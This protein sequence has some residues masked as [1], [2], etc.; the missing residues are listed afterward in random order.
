MPASTLEA[1]ALRLSAPPAPDALARLAGFAERLLDVPV[2]LITLAEGRAWCGPAAGARWQPRR[3]T[4]LHRS[5]CGVPARTGRTLLVE[6]A[7]AHPLVRENPALWMGEVA[8]A[9]APIRTA[10]GTV[11]GSI[12]A[13]DTR[14]RTWTGEDAEALEHLAAL[15]GV[16]LDR[17]QSHAG[18]AGFVGAIA[19]S[20]GRLS[21]RMLEKA[22]ETMQIGVTITDA[23]G[24]ILYSNPAEARMHGYAADELR[25]MHARVFAPP[26]HA[27]PI[28]RQE[29][30][31]VTS[32]MRETVNVRKD[33]TLFPVLLRSDVVK[34]SRGNVVGI[35]TCCEDIT[36]R[37]EMER[38]LLRNAFFDPVTG[39]PNRGLFSHRLELAVDRER[40]GEGDFAVLA[41]GIDR[42]ALIGES[43]GREAADELLA[44]VAARVRE[45]VKTETLVAHVARDE[46]AVL[47]D[48]VEGIA[49][50]SRVAACIQDSL[51]RPFPVAG[52]E[53]ATGASVG[54]ALSY[55][56]YERAED[57]LRDAAIALGRSRDARQGQYEVFDRE[58][59][60]R[61]MARLRMETELR[62]ALDRGE[63]R[64]H[65]QPIISLD[66]GRIAGF[67]ALVRWQHPERGLLAPDAFIPLAEET[68]L[69]LP[70]GTWVLE[71]A[72][73]ELRRWQ[74]RQGDDAP[75]TMAVNLCARQFLQADLAE[76]VARVLTETAIAPGT[77]KL[78]ITESVL[79]QH[80]DAV[81][82]TLHRLKA[83]GVQLHID[84]F[85]TGYSSL[86]YLHRLPLDALK[87]DRSFV[88]GG[89]G[90]NLPL[91]RTIVALAHALGVAVVTEGIESA[92][93]LSELRSLNCEFGQGYLFSHPLPGPEIDKL[94]ATQP[95]W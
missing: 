15:A 6:D 7:R 90:A 60:A 89:Q 61:A 1:L 25:G 79:M 12:C 74:D 71:E 81:T 72:C 32:W 45:C 4:P 8:Y 62:R 56:G 9:G 22:I 26:E 10:D 92:E 76:R 17:R 14:P 13:I 46:F 77:L 16:L 88:M 85:G 73:R 30:E 67:E 87:I 86:G 5:L 94:V 44:G 38:Q 52:T 66:S 69:I 91:V 31:G 50:T 24:R 19:G 83:L 36:Q 55:T 54:I 65:Y 20:R 27:Q 42:F 82:A 37:K 43:L 59:H 63:L 78:E 35:V 75:L 40:R 68:G 70:L 57:V 95:R 29:M 48:D 49:E 33:G 34:D 41:V 21:L 3:E 58:M 18:E 11:A 23:D 47:L 93:V 53:V 39:L 2:S 84:D 51:A 80:T 28:T 64:V